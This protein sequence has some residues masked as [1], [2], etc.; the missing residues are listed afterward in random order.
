VKIRQIIQPGKA[1]GLGFGEVRAMV[2]SE[3]NQ[4]NDQLLNHLPPFN[5]EADLQPSTEN[6][7]AVLYQRI[8][9]KLP[10]GL[11]PDSVTVWESPTNY[12]TYA[13]EDE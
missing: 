4:F 1:Y 9:Q 3:T 6:L 2:Q 13:E 10:A 12:V 5:T 11:R 8:R 7:A